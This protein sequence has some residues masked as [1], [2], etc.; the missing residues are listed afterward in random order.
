MNYQYNDGG[1]SLAGYQGTT[2]DCATRSIAIVTGKPYQEVYDAINTQALTER[3]GK[4][5]RGISNSRTGVYR[6]TIHKYLLGLGMKWTATMG[7]GTGCMVHLKENELP[8]G[9]LVVCVSKHYTAVVDGIIQDNHDCS[10]NE[11]RCVYGY[12]TF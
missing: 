11:T 9:K 7:I 2:G 10:R 4:R 12:Y 3:Q 6:Q 5:K 1:R 8:S